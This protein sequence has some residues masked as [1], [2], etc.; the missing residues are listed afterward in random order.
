M[1]LFSRTGL[2]FAWIQRVAQ[3]AVSV[4]GVAGDVT[5]EALVMST[6]LLKYAPVVG[7]Q[8]AAKMLLSIWSTLR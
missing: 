3:A 7:L 4:L 2:I 8:E 5:H 1:R 6:D